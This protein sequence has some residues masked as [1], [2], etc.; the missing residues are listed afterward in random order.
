[1]FMVLIVNNKYYKT[2]LTPVFPSLLT[3]GK[4]FIHL[5]MVSLVKLAV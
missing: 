2:I 4:L 5:S 3:I 1:M